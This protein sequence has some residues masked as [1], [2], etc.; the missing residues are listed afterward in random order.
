M[1]HIYLLF[2]C[3][4]TDRKYIPFRHVYNWFSNMKKKELIR[5]LEKVDM[6]LNYIMFRKMRKLT[7]GVFLFVFKIRK[8]NLKNKY[9]SNFL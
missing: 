2:R 8:I 4:I 6:L 9:S 3:N 1:N 7:N 5:N